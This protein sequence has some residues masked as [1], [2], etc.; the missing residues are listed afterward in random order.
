MGFE[1]TK[2]FVFYNNGRRLNTVCF[3]RVN[4][5]VF[6]GCFLGMFGLFIN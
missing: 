3:L 2:K 6:C 4:I 5:G 1:L